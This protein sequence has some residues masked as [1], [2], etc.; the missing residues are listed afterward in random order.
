[1]FNERSTATSSRMLAKFSSVTIAPS[2]LMM[3]VFSRNRG[4]Y[5]RMPRK[6]VGF[7]SVLLV[8]SRR[9]SQNLL[10]RLQA[11]CVLRWRTDGD[12]NPLGQLI[13]THWPHDD[14]L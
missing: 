14:A 5:C 9:E 6:S 11:T 7:T 3:N 12:A 13:P 2:T 1:M 10:Q 4:M 8:A